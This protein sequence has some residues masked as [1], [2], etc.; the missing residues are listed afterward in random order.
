MGPLD[1]LI[2]TAEGG[3]SLVHVPG[4]PGLRRAVAAALASPHEA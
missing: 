4:L 1:L 3:E 2:E